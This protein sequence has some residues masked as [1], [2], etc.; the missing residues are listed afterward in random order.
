MQICYFL[1][2]VNWIFVKEGNIQQCAH[3][4]TLMKQD[5]IRYSIVNTS[6]LPHAYNLIYI[7][8]LYQNLQPYSQLESMSDVICYN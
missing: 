8:F 6:A 5:N 1:L 3:A 7:L 4:E 2:H